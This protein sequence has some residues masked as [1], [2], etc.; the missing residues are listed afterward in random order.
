MGKVASE[1]LFWAWSVACHWQTLVTGGIITAILTAI[2]YKK[3]RSIPW[4]AA[5]RIMA[6]FLF[7]AFFLAWRDQYE[8]ANTAEQNAHKAETALLNRLP[9]QVIVPQSSQSNTKPEHAPKLQARCNGKY[10]AG[11]RIPL[12]IQVERPSNTRSVGVF[13]RNL[14]I[15]NIGNAPTGEI[16]LRLYL[17]KTTTGYGGAWIGTDSDEPGYPAAFYS[18]VGAMVINAQETWDWADFSTN[19]S[20]SD[21]KLV[22]A[23]LKVFYGAEKPDEFDFSF[24]AER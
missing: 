23:K 21:A 18:R 4:T 2:Q 3:Q 12:A 13:L 1:C 9:I 15:K 22:S 16:S 14:Q 24:F 19:L 6:A 10:L 11:Q 8:R 20:D 17:S 5:R 7:V